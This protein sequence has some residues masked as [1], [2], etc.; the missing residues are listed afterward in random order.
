MLTRVILWFARLSSVLVCALFLAILIGD[1]SH[2]PTTLQGWSGPFLLLL[3]CFGSVL[4]WKWQLHGS[5]ITLAA[6]LVYVLTRR[7]SNYVAVMFLAVPA[8]LFILAWTTG[9]M[10]GRFHRTAP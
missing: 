4:A 6:L 10:R 5:G 3:A 7:I 8:L 9:A 2:L 1:I